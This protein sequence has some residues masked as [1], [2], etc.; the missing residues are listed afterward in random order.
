MSGREKQRGNASLQYS[1]HRG[2]MFFCTGE[3]VVHEN[4][5]V[6]A[7]AD[8]GAQTTKRSVRKM[9]NCMQIGYNLSNLGIKN[10][11]PPL[12]HVWGA[13]TYTKSAIPHREILYACG[14][15]KLENRA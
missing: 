5:G 8:R 9:V 4:A 15:R 13:R 7:S 1:M 3:N 10:I 2:G 14:T 11:M 6:F 12:R